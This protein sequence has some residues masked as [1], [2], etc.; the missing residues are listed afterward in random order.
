MKAEKYYY[1][2][3][4]LDKYSDRLRHILIIVI[5][6]IIALCVFCTVNIVLR[7]NSP[8]AVLLFAVVVGSV[9]FGILFAFAAV[10]FTDKRIRRHA[11]YTFMDI[12]PSA[13]IYSEYAGEFVRYGELIILRR[14]YIIP[15]ADLE[16]VSR[17]PKQAPH[18]IKFKGKIREYFLETDRLG[19]HVDPDGNIR[20][21]TEILEYGYFS[22]ITEVTVK[23]RLGNTKR[24]ERA[25]LFYWEEFKNT[26]EKKPFD[27]SQFVRA[28]QKPKPKTSNPAL[29]APSFSRNWK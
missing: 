6:P 20:L 11:R 10:Y 4:D 3:A 1:F 17:D 15:F 12:I 28:R 21:D 9:L 23:N 16:S 24:I 2:H 5:I 14:L 18:N 8:L 29:E 27:I 26:P 19:Y 7:F 25:V 13:V 22:E